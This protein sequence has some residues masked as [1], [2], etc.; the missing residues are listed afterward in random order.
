MAGQ[1]TV[2]LLRLSAA[3]SLVSLA[4]LPN[5]LPKR[6]ALAL[7]VPA[8]SSSSSFFVLRCCAGRQRLGS[9]HQG[10]LHGRSEGGNWR[11]RK[12]GPVKDAP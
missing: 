11:N 9:A 6:F 10:R 8:C 3:A 1:R 12:E 4:L 5:Q 7:I 2:A